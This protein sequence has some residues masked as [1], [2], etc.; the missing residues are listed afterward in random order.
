MLKQIISIIYLLI[1]VV[2]IMSCGSSGGSNYSDYE[3]SLSNK[4][5]DTL[6]FFYASNAITVDKYNDIRKNYNDSA[7]DHKSDSQAV[8]YYEYVIAE[9]QQAEKAKIEI[10]EANTE[11][12]RLLILNKFNVTKD[13]FNG[14]EYYK[15]KVYGK[16]YQDT[17]TLVSVI[18]SSG[19]IWFR[20]NYYSPDWLFHESITILIEGIKYESKTIGRG[21]ENYV[22]EIK[23]GNIWEIVTYEDDK[24]I[25]EAIASNIDKVIKVRFNGRKHYDDITLS[26]KYK[27]AIADSYELSELIGTI[28]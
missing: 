24:S 22:T 3:D 9:M 10:A 28:K 12:L 15:P 13:E 17:K 21:S 26:K 27:Q 7:V 5:I 20:S 16:Y 11:K 18:S 14:T 1:F 19:F 8:A 2:L 23:G 6:E 4:L 25:I